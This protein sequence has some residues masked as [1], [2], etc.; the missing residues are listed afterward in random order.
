MKARSEK[1]EGKREQILLAATQTIN[2]KGLKGM[3]ISDVAPLLNMAPTSVAYYY[4]TKEE[5][6]A[7]CYLRSIETYTELIESAAG[8][9]TLAERLSHL[10]HAF[11][12]LMQD[13]ALGRANEIAIF[14][15]ILASG[16]GDVFKA[17]VAMFKA[18]R[19]LFVTNG[20]LPK[21]RTRVNAQTHLVLINL[22]FA[23]AWLQEYHPFSYS[24]AAT[25]FEDI[26]LNGIGRRQREW[27]PGHLPLV[28]QRGEADADP[29]EAFL[30]VATKL[31]NQHGYR[32]ASV[33]N[34]VKELNLT[35]GAFYHHID[36][37]DDL[38]ET[39]YSR[40]VDAIRFAQEA[41][42]QLTTDSLG[43]LE[44]ILADL[45]Q[46]Q[47]VGDVQLLRNIFIS[48]PEIIRRKIDIM[49]R[50]TETHFVSLV[51]D[52]IADGSLRMVDAHMAARI[53][54]CSLNGAVE[55]S[56]G[57]WLPSPLSDRATEHYVRPLFE[58][59]LSCEEK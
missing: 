9:P 28:D 12:T 26:M 19:S 33:E 24:R 54:S 38:I 55:L 23:H 34:I 52:G 10:V 5:L 36:F 39:C 59:L 4:R 32:G 8:L 27:A 16:E 22:S 42:D 48:V 15:D 17:Y 40:S 21:D 45:V 18:L 43:R 20:S 35:R 3:V 14:E 53:L 50:P 13:V 56:T 2:R 1:Y 25:R 29:Q 6:A 57:H 37:K 51:S 44:S 58:G 46:R 41:A 11:F 47:L 30:N 49:N 7:A 31:I